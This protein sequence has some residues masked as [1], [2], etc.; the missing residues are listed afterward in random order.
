MISVSSLEIVFC[1]FDVCFRSVVVFAC[2]GC[3]MITDD[4]SFR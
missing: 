4:W 2:D 3:L 1:G